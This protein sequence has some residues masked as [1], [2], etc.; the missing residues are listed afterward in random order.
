MS[1]T[2]QELR[3]GNKFSGMG[4]VQTVFAILD[5]TNRGEFNQAGYEH[6]ILCKENGNQYKPVECDPIPLTPDVLLACGF[7][8]LHTEY[9]DSFRLKPLLIEM[10]PDS[11]IMIRIELG[12]E[13]YA[14]VLNKDRHYPLH[15]LQNLFYSLTGAELNYTP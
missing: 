2:A 15:Q 1:I 4:M 5:N 6:L 9:C 8:D 11:D 13:N 10:L 14:Y 7:E 12:I 3:I